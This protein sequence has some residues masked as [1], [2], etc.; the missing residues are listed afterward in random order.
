MTDPGAEVR[1]DHPDQADI[2]LSRFADQLI[3]G[4]DRLRDIMRNLTST[5]LSTPVAEDRAAAVPVHAPDTGTEVAD[6]VLREGIR[7]ADGAGGLPGSPA[8]EPVTEGADG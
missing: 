7:I 1:H 6:Q 5:V 8:D 2:Q 3:A 4:A